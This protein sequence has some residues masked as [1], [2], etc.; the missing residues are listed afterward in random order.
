MR[1]RDFTINVY[2]THV[3]CTRVLWRNCKRKHS[4]HPSSYWDRASSWCSKQPKLLKCNRFSEC[5]RYSKAPQQS[6]TQVWCVNVTRG[7]H[8][9]VG[10]TWVTGLYRK[11]C[12][13]KG[14]VT[15]SVHISHAVCSWSWY[16][17]EINTGEITNSRLIQCY[18]VGPIPMRSHIPVQ[19]PVDMGRIMRVMTISYNTGVIGHKLFRP[20]NSPATV[21]QGSCSLS[22]QNHTSISILLTVRQ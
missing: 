19:F 11:E 2:S 16:M 1:G 17:S 10:W 4:G 14:T 18:M 7:M 21:Q 13:T 5:C 22:E 15:L 8:C 6:H 12:F 9:I 3:L 20:Y